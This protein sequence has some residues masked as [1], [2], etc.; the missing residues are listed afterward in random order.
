MSTPKEQPKPD[1]SVANDDG[2]FVNRPSGKLDD[3]Y[4]TLPNHP[5][6]GKKT[7]RPALYSF[8]ELPLA[9][10]EVGRLAH[11][12]IPG[13]LGSGGMGIVFLA[14]DS[15]LGRK[16]ALKVMKA[17]EDDEA[18]SAGLRFLTEARALA[19]I[20]HDHLVTIF[21]VGQAGETY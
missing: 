8:L 14:E 18:L 13:L 17:R 3:L 16:V 4:P 1:D 10:D 5:A 15:K 21:D 19:K 12:R 11:F 9:D 7:D 6:E 2:T 20:K